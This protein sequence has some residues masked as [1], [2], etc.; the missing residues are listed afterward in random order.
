MP[1]K[2]YDASLASI[3]I[4]NEILEMVRPGQSSKKIF[5]ASVLKA[6]ALGYADYYLGIPG[7]KV[8]FVGHGIG[9]ELIEPPFIASKTKI[10]LEPGMVFALEPKMV[11]ENEFTAGIENIVVIDTEDCLFICAKNKASEI[12]KITEE[13]ENH[14]KFNRL[15]NF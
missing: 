2:A 15:L 12:K 11:F 10:I 14:P 4:F 13:L 9:V 3:E 8:S 5:E 1:E 7:H 6:K